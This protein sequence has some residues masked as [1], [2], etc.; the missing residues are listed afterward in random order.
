MTSRK[1]TFGL[2]WLALVAHSVIF[3]VEKVNSSPPGFFQ[4]D[5]DLIINMSI[6]EWDG[7]NPII[8]AIFFIMAILPWVYGAFI[9]FD[10]Q[11]QAFSPY[12]FFIASFGL[13]AYALVPY[14][15]LRQPDT[16][17]QKKKGLLLKVLDSRLMAMVSLLSVLALV[18]WGAI[19]GDWSDFVNQWQNSQFVHLMSTDFCIL[20]L[21]LSI[22]ILKDD[23][24]RRQIGDSKL[25]WLAVLIPLFGILIYWCVRPQLSSAFNSEKLTA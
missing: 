19:N 6:L 10:S 23:M 7:I 9:L 11:E 5:L 24:K 16:T 12:P 3:T 1:I 18:I 13:G 20:S 17:W 2:M 8:I 14:F 25:F 4:Q 22:A 15:A 21:L